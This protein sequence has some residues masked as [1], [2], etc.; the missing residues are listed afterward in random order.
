MSKKWQVTRKG[1]ELPLQAVQQLLVWDLGLW[2]QKSTAHHTFW[3]IQKCHLWY[4]GRTS[5]KPFIEVE[6]FKEDLYHDEVNYDS[7]QLVTMSSV[8]MAPVNNIRCEWNYTWNEQLLLKYKVCFQISPDHLH[9][10]QAVGELLIDNPGPLADSQVGAR[11]RVQ[12]LQWLPIPVKVR[13]VQQV[14][15]RN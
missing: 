7:L 12:I 1:E 2:V 15:E 14:T 13:R 4:W 3:G 8:N 10:L 9:Y 11:L 6:A 5:G